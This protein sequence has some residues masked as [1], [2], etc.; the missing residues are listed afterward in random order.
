MVKRLQNRIAQSRWALPITIIYGLVVCLTVELM[1]YGQWMTFALLLVATLMMAELNNGYSLIRIYSRMVSCSFMVMITMSLTLFESVTVAVVMVAFIAFLLL[2]FRAYQNPGAVGWVFYAFVALGISSIV[3]SKS[4]LFVPV[5][6]V[7]MAVN[8]LC[9]SPRTL[10][11]SLLGII[12]P[13]WFVAA[14]LIYQGNISYLGTHFLSALQFG[15]PFQ[16]SILNIHQLLTFAFVLVL[17]VIGAVHFFLYSYQDRIRIRLMYET[18]VV[19]DACAVIFAI[20]QPQYFDEMLGMSIVTTAT[21]IGHFLALTHSRLSNI[22]MFV[23]AGV[24]LALTIFNLW[25]D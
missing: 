23:L 17:A 12:T 10:I 5:L 3:F 9:F 11:A 1:G 22:T 7:I 2:I 18:F 19:L 6:W 25:L 20:L 16:F 4:L 8:V 14:W 13:Y 21:L 15:T 24:T